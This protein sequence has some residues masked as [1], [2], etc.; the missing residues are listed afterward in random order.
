MRAMRKGCRKKFEGGGG[1]GKKFT[2]H[3]DAVAGER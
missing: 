2:V 1:G 3:A